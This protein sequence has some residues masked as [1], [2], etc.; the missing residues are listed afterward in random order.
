MFSLTLLSLFLFLV[1]PPLHSFNVASISYKLV[2]NPCDIR[3]CVKLNKMLTC[4]GLN[5]S[6]ISIIES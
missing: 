4:L 5:I 3:D 6:Q 2:S 1:C